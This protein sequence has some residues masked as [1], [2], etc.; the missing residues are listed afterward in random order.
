MQIKFS[1][2]L[3]KI[4]EYSRNEALRTGSYGMSVDHLMLGLLRDADNEAVSALCRL[5]IDPEDMKK[6]IDSRIFC[7]TAIP[8]SELENIKAT[9]GAQNVLNMAAF[10]ALKT[11]VQELS[12]AHLL[13]A[14]C[15]TTGNAS[16]EYLLAHGADR[17]SVAEC[18]RMPEGN[19]VRTESIKLE[20]IA[21]ALAE[22]LSNLIDSSD[23]KTNT[24][25]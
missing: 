15:L 1:E 13:L 24:L 21:G 14:I 7:Q 22:Q 12:P 6:S 25:S 11:G 8:Y 2:K 10:E 19:P 20:D 17:K 3:A 5:S 18:M 23:K 4:I 9:R 16:S